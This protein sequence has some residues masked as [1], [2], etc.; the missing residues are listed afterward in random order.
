M[1]RVDR[2]TLP[3]LWPVQWVLRITRWRRDEGFVR[4]SIFTHKFCPRYELDIVMR[5]HFSGCGLDRET[6]KRLQA[7]DE[8]RLPVGSPAYLIAKMV[9]HLLQVRQLSILWIGTLACVKS[10]ARR[11]R[12]WLLPTRSRMDR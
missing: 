2:L 1:V 9:Q 12:R 3:P 10:T 11:I 4:Y 7:R 6:S 8:S 5:S